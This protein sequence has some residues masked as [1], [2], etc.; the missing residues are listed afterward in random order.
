[1]VIA[2]VPER[3]AQ[4]ELIY[5]HLAYLNIVRLQL[6][7][8][9]PWATTRENLHQTFVSEAAELGEYE[10]AIGR[11]FTDM[12][13]MDIYHRIKERANLASGALVAQIE[14]L[15]ELKRAKS[16]DDFEHSDLVRQMAT[17]FDL[18]GGCERIKSTPLY[19][20]FSIFSRVFVDLFISLLP[21]ALLTEMAGLGSPWQIWLPVPFSL[22]IS[23]VFFT[24]EQVGEYSENPFDNALNDTP[25][26]TICRN[27]E[28]E[29]LEMLGETKLPARL[30]VTNDI[31]L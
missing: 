28:I 7:R 24:M 1:M 17:L 10:V 20:Q 22:L 6:R 3:P 25:M 29:L 16:I 9:G 11:L 26:A 12:G 4:E 27:I 13:K 21:V 30:P 14:T 2:L 18:Q 8:T 23:W 5:R 15:T 31:M 19:R